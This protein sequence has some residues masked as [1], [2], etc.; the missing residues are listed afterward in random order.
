MK[1]DSTK[2][3]HIEVFQADEA[4]RIT[5]GS[6]YSEERVR[7]AV[8]E[9]H[10]SSMNV[11]SKLPR[12]DREEADGVGSEA[13]NTEKQESMLAA[14]D[15]GQPYWF[16]FESETGTEIGIDP[17][18]HHKHVLISGKDEEERLAALVNQWRLIVERGCGAIVH[19]SDGDTMSWYR[20]QVRQCGRGNDFIEICPT[21]PDSVGF[22]VLGIP[23]EEET[24]SEGV[25]PTRAVEAVNNTAAGLIGHST[26]FKKRGGLTIRNIVS[27]T[28]GEATLADIYYILGDR[29]NNDILS[30]ERAQWLDETFPEKPLSEHDQK[31][32]LQRIRHWISN[33]HVRDS[34]ATPNPAVNIPKA[35][36][37]Q[38]IVAIR[39]EHSSGIPS[40]MVTMAALICTRNGY[41]LQAAS[42]HRGSNKQVYF[43]TD[44]VESL[45]DA[46]PF[47]KM[48]RE[49]RPYGITV[50]GGCQRTSG[51]EKANKTLRNFGTY[52]TYRPRDTDKE[53]CARQHTRNV[54]QSDLSK[55]SEGTAYLRTKADKRLLESIKVNT[56]EL[57]ESE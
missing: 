3:R 10:D 11:P 30:S 46:G 31:A 25:E 41:G 9:H 29:E 14:S 49:L 38:K 42:G 36:N 33:K 23:E 35:L 24:N 20:D 48:L 12:F 19:V 47:L 44:D 57:P 4:G 52:L 17:T 50:V 39:G 1:G 21:A 13:M 56:F 8:L 16:G 26:G 53:V 34:I 32:V 15:Y 5:L 2:D 6:E 43:V 18:A 28:D 54:T 45:S 37:E 22:N 27:I 40:A 51:W 55:L 7:V